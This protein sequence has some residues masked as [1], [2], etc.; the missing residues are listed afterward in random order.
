MGHEDTKNLM[1]RGDVWH[2]VKMHK[3]KRLSQSTGQ[4]K[5]KLARQKRDYFL[6]RIREGDVMA[7]LGDR[8]KRAIANTDEILAAYERVCAERGHPRPETVRNN[9]RSF[10][11]LIRDAAGKDTVTATALDKGL[12]TAY[13]RAKLDE[14]GDTPSVRR[15]MLSTVTQARCVVQKDL[16]QDYDLELPDLSEFRE[17]FLGRYP[18]KEVPLPPVDLRL[19]LM[20]SAR[21]L[22]LDRDP[23]YLVYLL[24][25]HLGMRS[26]EMVA[27]RWSWLEEHRGEM[28]MALRDRPEEGYRI[29]G[30][31][32]GNVPIHPAVLR[33][34]QEF[35]GDS[36]YIL[37]GDNENQRL[38]LVGRS[39]AQLMTE[40][41]W[42]EVDTTKRA[43][44]LRRLFGSAV[45]FKYGKEECFLRMRHCSFATTER[46]YLNL[47]L[48]LMPREL[49]GI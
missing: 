5:L 28:R 14:H 8:V 39:F 15:S 40:L 43:H 37:P 48:D 7:L 33:R 9:V 11:R 25:R 46:N 45:W 16:I 13:R 24:A 38:N 19:G 44:E 32:A 31:R 2:F 30:V 47:N 36:E 42:S 3:G 4:T 23:L 22:W 29:K 20:R 1:L 35:R 34:L 21:R 18:S 49:V 10:R 27:A 17:Y 6:G 12:L 41:G 26:G